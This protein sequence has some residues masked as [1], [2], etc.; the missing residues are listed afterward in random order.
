M[1]RYDLWEKQG[2]SDVITSQTSGMDGSLQTRYVHVSTLDVWKSAKRRMCGV[3]AMCGN[4]NIQMGS[5]MSVAPC[6]HAQAE[7]FM[8]KN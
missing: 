5:C 2:D 3:G 8:P 7:T 1:R 6:T 4:V